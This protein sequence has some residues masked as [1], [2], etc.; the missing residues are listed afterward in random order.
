[1]SN[2]PDTPHKHT[3]TADVASHFE[4]VIVE[5]ADAADACAFF[6]RNEA[7]EIVADLPAADGE[8]SFLPVVDQDGSPLAPTDD[9]TQRT[10]TSQRESIERDA[11]TGRKS[12]EERD[13][14]SAW[15]YATGDGFV[16]RLEM[17]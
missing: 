11:A 14:T 12:S 8:V 7:I 13:V 3:E 17:R 10:G 1:M 16:D 15:L 6:L 5:R 4:H 2:V 9:R